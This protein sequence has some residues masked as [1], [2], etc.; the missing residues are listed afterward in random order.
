MTLYVQE[1]RAIPLVTLDVWVRVGSGD[2]PA[3]LEGISHFLEH[4][5]FKGTERLRT[6]DYDRRI[7]ELGGYLNAG[8][9]SDYTHYYITVPSEHAGRVLSDLA[10]VL[11]NS[12]IDPREVEN[13][14]SVILEEIRRKADSPMGYLFDETI[15]TIFESGPYRHPVIGSADSVKSI[16]RDQLLEHYQ[17]FY[18]ADRIALVIVGDVEAEAV[19]GRVESEFRDLRKES[20]AYREAAPET[21]YAQPETRR[22]PRPW[23]EAYFILAFP[24]PDAGSVEEIAVADSIEAL[25]ADGRSSRLVGSLQERKGIVNNIGVYLPSKLHPM[26]CLIYGTC[27]PERVEEVRQEIFSELRDLKENGIQSHEMKRVRRQVITSHLFSLETNAGRASTIGYSHLFFQ[28]TRLLD[29]FE[30]VL[31]G[32]GKSDLEEY[33]QKHFLE[34]ESY[35]FVTAQPDGASEE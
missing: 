35:F 28:D 12:Q 20:R 16:T 29:G 17:R 26:P 7:E 32:A 5:L 33:I 22:L 34:D 11:M 23:N 31:R 13:E 6:G 4:M 21:K 3:G 30:D 9:S 15:P 24:G 1:S 18:A 27:A 19:R 2:E 10:D 14:R 25:L 8:T